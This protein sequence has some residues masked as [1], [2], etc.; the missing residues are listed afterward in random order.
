[1]AFKSGE[2]RRNKYT[3]SEILQERQLPVIVRDCAKLNEEKIQRAKNVIFPEEDFVLD[4][5]DRV[6]VALVLTRKSTGQCSNTCFIP[7]LCPVKFWLQRPKTEHRFYTV[8]QVTENCL[9][10]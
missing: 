10:F 4:K 5:I 2:A 3:I 6:E 9:F 7:A 1:M 8:R